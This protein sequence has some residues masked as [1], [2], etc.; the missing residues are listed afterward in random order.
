[1]SVHTLVD[2]KCAESNLRILR[3]MFRINIGVIATTLICL[4]KFQPDRLKPFLWSCGAAMFC[5]GTLDNIGNPGFV[6]EASGTTRLI[7]SGKDLRISKTP[8][9]GPYY[10]TIY[11]SWLIELVLA[12]LG[13]VY[14][15]WLFLIPAA[16]LF[17]RVYKFYNSEPKPSDIPSHKSYSQKLQDGHGARTKAIIR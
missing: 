5:Y 12:T 1:M 10:L 14:V 4:L 13:T 3:Y 15:C 17:A 6:T 8:A 9:L 7:R 2:P 16:Y 11:I